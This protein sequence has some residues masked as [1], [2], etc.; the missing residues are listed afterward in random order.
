MRYLLRI[1]QSNDTIINQAINL[2]ELWLDLILQ[3]GAELSSTKR[4]LHVDNYLC[5]E[6]MAV[7]LNALIFGMQ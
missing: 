5:S 4:K 7:I 1:I 2:I 6:D 3:A